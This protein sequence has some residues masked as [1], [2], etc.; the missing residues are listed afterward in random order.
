MTLTDADNGRTIDLRVGDVVVLRLSESAASGYRWEWE[1]RLEDVVR[2]VTD[3]YAPPR[4]AVGGAGHS[5][6]TLEAARPG[7][8]R[9]RLKQ[10]REWEGESSVASRFEVVLQVHG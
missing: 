1:E 3:A 4:H 6:W 10:W 9:L 5:Q 2:V 7:T 8:A